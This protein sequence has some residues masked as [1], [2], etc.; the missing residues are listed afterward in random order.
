[1]LAVDFCPEQM[2]FGVPRATPNIRGGDGFDVLD[3]HAL[4]QTDDGADRTD[5]MVRAAH[6]MLEVARAH[7]AQ[8][9]LLMDIS[10]ACGSQVIYDGPRHLGIYR[11]GP[12][13]ATALLVRSGLPVVS[14]RDY[15]T[16][17]VILRHLG[18]PDL[19]LPDGQDHHESDW[20]VRQFRAG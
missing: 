20:Y 19:A 13:V 3:G 12:G 16:L 1:V 4:V 14:Q 2:A 17:G 18:R 6:R 8:L 5:E 11:A 15:R 7:D 9:A 10:A